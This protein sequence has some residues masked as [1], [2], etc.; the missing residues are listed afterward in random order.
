[1]RSGDNALEL[2]G[3]MPG[4]AEVLDVFIPIPCTAQC[5]ELVFKLTK[6]ALF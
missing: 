6:A 4:I 1:M 3:P 2:C 5:A